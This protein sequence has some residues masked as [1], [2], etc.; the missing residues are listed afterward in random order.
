MLKG[1]TSKHD[2]ADCRSS[3]LS[4]QAGA[5]Q[6]LLMPLDEFPRLHCATSTLPI[7]WTFRR[8]M[9][10]ATGIGSESFHSCSM[11]LSRLRSLNLKSATQS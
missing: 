3:E 5:Q 2:S 9:K 10:P 4:P 1:A 11:E 8:K 7:Q 6:D